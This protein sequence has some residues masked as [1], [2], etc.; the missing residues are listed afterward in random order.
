MTN[1]LEGKKVAI[2][3]ADGVEKVELEQPRAA[4]REAGAQVELLSLKDGEI[5]ARNHDLEPAGTF[6]VD[7]VVAEASVSEFDGLVLPGGTVNPDKL[8]MDS[9]AVSFVRDFASSGKPVAAICHG[10]WTLLEAGVAEG[11]TLT[12][13]PSIRTD[14]RNAG[15]NVVD[16]E[17][18][19]DGNLITSRS[20]KDL[21][22]F[23][24]T[25]LQQF[26]HAPAS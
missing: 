9:A 17:V 1:E 7:R 20:P 12:S 13:Y 5:Q 23:C 15:A 16:E 18:V 24:A 14:L 21:P 2:L 6:K 10:P 26:A 4:L 3:A 25:I 11:R 22:A 8:R 19:V